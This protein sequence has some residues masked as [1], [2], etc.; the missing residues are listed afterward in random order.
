MIVKMGM[1]LKAF[2]GKGTNMVFEDN[3]DLNLVLA[4]EY[5]VPNNPNTPAQETVRSGFTRATQA[6]EALPKA[7]VDLW[8]AYAGQFKTRNKAG[9]LRAKRGLNVY[10]ALGT[11]MLLVNPG[12]T[13]PQDPPASDFSGDA[14]T[15]SATA[16]TGKITFTASAPNSVGVVTELLYIKL[17]NGNRKPGKAYKTGAYFPFVL[18][19]LTKDVPV[20][21]GYYAAGYRFVKIST[22]QQS[23][24][25][26]LP[27]T[28]VT[29]SVAKKAA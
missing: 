23:E 15:V 6:F 14:I 21:P 4:R 10:A 24:I 17:V 13:L 3:G 18:G 29:F 7:K 9:K 8:N 26:P 12:A 19:T 2:S 20:P 16:G 25:R 28:Q 1:G 5:V 11:K 27:V 22:G